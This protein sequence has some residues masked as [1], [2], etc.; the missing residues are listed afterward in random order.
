MRK[1]K[2]KNQIIDLSTAKIMGILNITPDSFSD[3][4]CFLEKDNALF[5]AE[6]LIRNGAVILDIG[7]ES[8]RP[9]SRRIS[10]SEELDRISDITE[11]II[12]EF[13]ILISIDT[14][15]AD[16]AREVLNFGI[17]MI[18]D[19]YGLTHSP[20]IAKL[21]ADHDAALCIMHMKGNP[22]TMQDS[23]N[24]QNILDEVH[25]FLFEKAKYA[26]SKGLAKDK[27]CLDPGIGFGKD[28]AGNLELISKYSDLSLKSGYEVLMGLSRKSFIGQILNNTPKE[29]LT[30]TLAANI[31]AYKNGCRF[32]RVHDV[33]EHYEAFKI[34]DAFN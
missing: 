32:F 27:I 13:D 29:R 34:L 3:G 25:E 11:S 5:Q 21:C 31:E 8:S 1:L 12:K 26:E 23:T 14:Y 6:K 20:E 10:A 16:V 2:L 18:N 24:Y 19:I 9:G 28:L 15:K 30:G 4:N 33:K 17:A 7:G 22:E